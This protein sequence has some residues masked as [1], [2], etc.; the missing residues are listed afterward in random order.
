[1]TVLIHYNST[2]AYVSPAKLSVLTVGTSHM[3]TQVQCTLECHNGLLL[4]M[5]NLA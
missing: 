1:L 4:F 3:Y 5:V 2:T